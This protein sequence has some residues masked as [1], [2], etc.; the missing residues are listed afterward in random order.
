[1]NSN[2][3]FDF[4]VDKETNTIIIKRE[5][6]ANVKLVWKAWTTAELLDQWWGPAPCRAKTK[7]MDFR[8]GG[9]WLYCMIVPSSLTGAETDQLHWG[10]QDFDTIVIEKSFSG[11]D[12]FCDEN[13]TANSELPGGRFENV[14]SEETNGRTLVTMTSKHNSFKDI[15]T[16]IEMGFKE[17]ITVCLNQLEEILK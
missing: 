14:F 6:D 3:L 7:S 13:G 2:L 16:M 5:F 1:M 10:K 11:T 4:V 9:H 8:E 17:G 12:V 15:E